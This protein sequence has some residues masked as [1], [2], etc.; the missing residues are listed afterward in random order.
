MARTFPR[1][2]RTVGVALLAAPIHA[3]RLAL[4]P[5][6]P[7]SCRF[8]LSCSAYALEALNRHGP[9]KGGALAVRRLDCQGCVNA[10]H[11]AP[12]GPAALD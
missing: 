8:Q 9:V 12:L 1:A 2:V 10:A 6:F 11:F 4:S 3:Y 7:P 5:F